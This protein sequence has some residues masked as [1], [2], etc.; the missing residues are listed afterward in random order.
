MNDLQRYSLSKSK[1]EEKE[2]KKLSKKKIMKN[3]S[4]C[5]YLKKKIKN[6]TRGEAK[7]TRSFLEKCKIFPC[8]C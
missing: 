2:R 5:L 3:F 8:L 1:K 4:S 7:R 6:I